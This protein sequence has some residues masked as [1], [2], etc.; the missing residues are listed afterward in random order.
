M[1]PEVWGAPTGNAGPHFN[2]TGF[3]Q[4]IKIKAR[5]CS[6][7]L[8]CQAVLQISFIYC[9]LS[10]PFNISISQVSLPPFLYC[11]F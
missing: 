11:E 6:E 2:L 10:K 7:L 4:H 3:K 1:K 9:Y 8:H 5:F